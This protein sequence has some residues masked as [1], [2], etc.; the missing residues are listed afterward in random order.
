[1]SRTDHQIKNIF[2]V[3]GE[4]FESSLAR[5][6]PLGVGFQARKVYVL[7]LALQ[8]RQRRD[9]LPTRSGLWPDRVDACFN[10]ILFPV[11]RPAGSDRTEK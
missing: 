1:M 6:L 10:S 7:V 11:E 3:P 8:S 5:A 4:T 9:I 2:S